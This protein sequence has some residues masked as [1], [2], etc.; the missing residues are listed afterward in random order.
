MTAAL[1]PHPSLENL[2]KQAKTLRK[3][4]RAGDSETL[5]RVRAAH[6]QYS[7]MPDQELRESKPRLTDCQLVLAR[8]AGFES[9]PQLKVA[10]E[11]ANREL[12]AQFVTLACL[13]YDDPHFDHRNFHAR[14]HEMLADRPELAGA[15]IWSAAAAYLSSPF[16]LRARYSRICARVMPFGELPD[17]VCI[18]F[19][20][21]TTH[22]E[23]RR[24]EP[25][26]SSASSLRENT[27]S[28]RD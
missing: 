27:L 17:D 5:A 3:K 11:S 9:W 21:S 28:V 24:Q 14:A 25:A 13:C 26:S 20:I 22:S 6:P 4:W 8:E 18:R 16:R 15:T 23:S 2:R 7:R 12:A 19:L 1:P 10:V